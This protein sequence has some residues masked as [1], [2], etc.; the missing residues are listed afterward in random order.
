MACDMGK[1]LKNRFALKNRIEKRTLCNRLLWPTKS[2]L[3]HLI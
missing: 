1:L 2:K 3:I